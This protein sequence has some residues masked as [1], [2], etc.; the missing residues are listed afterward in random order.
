MQHAMQ[1][2]L[3]DELNGKSLLELATAGRASGPPAAGEPTASAA[4]PPI[5]G[6]AASGADSRGGEIGPAA[7]APHIHQTADEEAAAEQTVG[8]QPSHAEDA[9]ALERYGACASANGE[10]AVATGRERRRLRA[11]RLPRLTRSRSASHNSSRVAENTH[12]C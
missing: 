12:L 8:K 9:E 7:A 10:I 11:R 2:A 1:N 5:K 3:D 6:K 4:A